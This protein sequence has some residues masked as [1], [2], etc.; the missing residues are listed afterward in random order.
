MSSPR[1]IDVH[2]HLVPPDY[3]QMLRDKGI[4]P[5][6]IPLPSWA[7][8]VASKIM[9]KNGVETA[10]LSVSTP[11][12]W[13]GDV[14]EARLWARRVNEHAAG[15]VA[16]QPRHFG[17]FATLTLP[18]V[19]GAIAEA[20]HALDVLGADGIVLLANNAG[21]YL[22]DPTFD[23]LLGFLHERRAVVFIHPGEL[24]GG[25]ADGIP[26]FTADFL[27][28]TTRTAISLILSGA[29]EQYDGIR[30]VLAHAG[31]FVPYIAHRIL[32]TTLREEPKWKLAGM[33]LNRKAEVARRMQMFKRF[34]FDIALSATPTTFPSLLA[35]ADPAKVL[36][37]SDFPFAPA[38]AVKYM[39]QEYESIDLSKAV[40]QGI[41]RG[42]AEVLFP[43]LAAQI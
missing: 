9:R 37:G 22:G 6:G 39:R 1:R 17:F 34:W 18:D 36:F 24:P 41:D 35:V 21:L 16:A 31:G 32:L 29:L 33:A 11:G 2:H 30:F 38:M 8:P 15:I 40:R 43:R 19:D 20:T 26:S 27:L 28:D 4:Q 23:R 25:P 10:I 7:A 12:V 42:N 5:G 14:P 3:A 13:F